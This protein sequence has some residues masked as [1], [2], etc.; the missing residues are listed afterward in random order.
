[1]I[2]RYL[3]SL[4]TACATALWLASGA[5]G[6]NCS[7]AAIA[8]PSIPNGQ[9]LDVSAYPVDNYKH[10]DSTL[11][12]CNVTITY[13]HPSWH[14][15]I[16]IFIWLPSTD[17]SQRLQSAGGSGWSA[18][19]SDYSLAEAVNGK[20]A[21]VGT[22]AGHER[23]PTS[24]GD[25]SLDK[26]GHANIPL[27]KDFAYVAL[28]DAAVVAKGVVRDFYG[29]GPRYSY[30]NGCS[31]GG[32]Q[33]LM[34]A[35]RY[36]TVFDGILAN[37]PA[38]NWA[39]FVVAEFWPSFVMNQMQH[40]PPAC[41]MNAIT[42]AT[43]QAC[44]ADD[45]VKDQV[46]SDPDRCQFDPMTM[47]NHGVNCS[48]ES[49]PVTEKDVTVVLKSWEGMRAPDGSFLWY[50]LE[51]G[52]PLSQGL[53]GV[54]CTTGPT[55]CTGIPFSIAADW[56]SQFILENPSTNLTSLNHTQLQQIFHQSLNKFNRI[57][58]TDNPDLSA[59]KKAGRKMI[60]WH[61][62]ADELI[63]PKGTEHYYNQVAAGDPSV[64]DYYRLFLAPGVNH[65][66]D[67]KGALPIDALEP[68][69]NWVEKGI[70]PEKIAARTLDQVRTRDLCPYPLVSVYKG[71]DNRKASSYAC[72]KRPT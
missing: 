16:H 56:I 30:W 59:F 15:D 34:M 27:L 12:F 23:N 14:D 4:S 22:D 25:W 35:Q 60:T 54:N 72:E 5:Q 19:K 29:N 42:D 52:A 55:N 58:G 17:W 66:K 8:R 11:D 32:R 28:N 1:M 45:G 33:G 69:V 26:S 7:S 57:I 40:Y 21:V 6:N 68:V 71:G 51:K 44:D 47:V 70:A 67:G 46:I 31:T 64:H 50:G 37:A 65:C 3:W 38:I 63:F 2:L 43:V 61:G 20:Y 18:L 39:K 41:V 48:G 53:A 36:P 10:R 13:T 62:L 9:V 49:I 24:S